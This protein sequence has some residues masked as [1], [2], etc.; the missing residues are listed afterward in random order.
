MRG[1]NKHG[2]PTCKRLRNLKR[3]RHNRPDLQNNTA[4]KVIFKSPYEWYTLKML[5]VSVDCDQLNRYMARVTLWMS[6][7]TYSYVERHPSTTIEHVH[8]DVRTTPLTA[9]RRK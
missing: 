3:V 4:H 7:P 2:L 5:T 1:V 9:E 8:T 6:D